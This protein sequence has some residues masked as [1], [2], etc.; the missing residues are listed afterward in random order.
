MPPLNFPVMPAGLL[1]EVIAKIPSRYYRVLQYF[2]T[3][4]TVAHNQW[5]RPTLQYSSIYS[6][7]IGNSSN[8]G[9]T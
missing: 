8:H 9:W 7:S 3:V 1:V 6:R 5:Y 2:F 4:L